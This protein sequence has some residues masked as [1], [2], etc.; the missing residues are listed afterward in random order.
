[1]Y[2]KEVLVS[3]ANKFL[4]LLSSH[5]T[6]LKEDTVFAKPTDDTVHVQLTSVN[7][8]CSPTFVL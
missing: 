2:E 5:L 7:S 4:M 1:M 3:S 6:A 8:F